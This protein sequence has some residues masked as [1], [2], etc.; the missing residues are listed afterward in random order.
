MFF[1][2]P[3]GF[4]DQHLHQHVQEQVAQ[5]MGAGNED[6]VV[7]RAADDL[8]S[9]IEQFRSWIEPAVD[10]MGYVNV[11]ELL[12]LAGSE[13]GELYQ[14]IHGV[15]I[16]LGSVVQEYGVISESV[17]YILFSNELDR[18]VQGRLAD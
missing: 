14:V 17:D 18:V 3:G 15:L 1:G 10:G 12:A 13:Q 11:G 7:D 4:P 5:M 6:V 2:A 9:R 16:A 8:L